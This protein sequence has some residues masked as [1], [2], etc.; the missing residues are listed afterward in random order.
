[1]TETTQEEKLNAFL[2]KLHAD[3]EKKRIELAEF[4]KEIERILALIAENEAK[5]VV[6]QTTIT[7]PIPENIRVLEAEKA[8]QFG[9]LAELNA[10][11]EQIAAELA[12]LKE[13]K[14]V[15]EDKAAVVKA[16]ILALE[17]E[18]GQLEGTVDSLYLSED[19][20]DSK[21]NDEINKHLGIRDEIRARIKAHETDIRRDRN[22]YDS[23]L[24]ALATL[25]KAISLNERQIFKLNQIVETTEAEFAL[26]QCTI[27]AIHVKLF[28]FFLFVAYIHC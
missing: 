16:E 13:K 8:R 20:E 28:S 25:E 9:I 11:L 2:D 12:V 10:K 24:V 19:S 21:I 15:I 1:M 4:L 14:K 26:E 27:D 17:A 5:C 23:I 6:I 3:L 18:I 7:V 22:T